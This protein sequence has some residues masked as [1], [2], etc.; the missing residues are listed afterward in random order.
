VGI[1]KTE[2][3]EKKRFRRK[4]DRTSKQSILKVQAAPRD[5]LHGTG[6]P[7]RKIV[8]EP[9][10]KTQGWGGKGNV[11]YKGGKGKKREFK[12][13]RAHWGKFCPKNSNSKKP[14]TR[15]PQFSRV[16]LG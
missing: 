3:W 6:R 16:F 9:G 8:K 5:H 10:K 1:P 7:I 2:S 4:K 14:T 15:D 12:S 13:E 11:A